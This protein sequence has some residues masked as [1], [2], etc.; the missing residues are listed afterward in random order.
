MTRVRFIIG[1]AGCLLSAPVMAADGTVDA[2]ENI[3]DDFVAYF[4]SFGGNHQLNPALQEA[5]EELRREWERAE[6]H[7][8]PAVFE[9]RLKNNPDLR[10]AADYCKRTFPQ[11]WE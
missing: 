8:G 1:L 4:Q 2:A 5:K 11:F 6:Q 3:I 7:C 10:E 9:G